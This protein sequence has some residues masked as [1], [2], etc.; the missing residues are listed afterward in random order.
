MPE[1][2]NLL[3]TGPREVRGGRWELT[4]SP[5]VHSCTELHKQCGVKGPEIGPEGLTL[6]RFTAFSVRLP[7]R[8]W[9]G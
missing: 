1:T 6:Q 3:L 4:G 8:W 2:R 7:C 9:I 5:E